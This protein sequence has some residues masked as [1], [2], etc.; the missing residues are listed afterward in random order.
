VNSFKHLENLYEQVRINKNDFLLLENVQNF[1]WDH[2]WNCFIVEDQ[3]N[4]FLFER[5]EKISTSET[6]D[7]WEIETSNGLIFSVSINFLEKVDVS[8]RILGTLISNL[9]YAEQLKSLQEA[10]KKTNQPILNVNF[11]DSE[12]NYALTNKVKNYTFFVLKGVKT[13]ITRSLHERTGTIPDVLFFYFLKS[14]QKKFELFK[15]LFADCFSQLTNNFVDENS[16]AQ[17]DLAYFWKDF[18]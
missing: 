9:S 18:A 13:A 11:T 8:D 16:S 3:N 2:F 4:S 14:E 10:V 12:N 15:R 5:L 17:Y 1:D 6:S 7:I